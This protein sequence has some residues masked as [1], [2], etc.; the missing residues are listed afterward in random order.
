[1][2]APTVDLLELVGG[3]PSGRATLAGAHELDLDVVA[4]HHHRRARAVVDETRDAALAEAQDHVAD[5]Q[6]GL[7]R[8]G[9]RPRR[10]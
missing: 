9:V 8:G 1:M 7:R 10:R 3:A 6:A 5:L 2:Q 4:D